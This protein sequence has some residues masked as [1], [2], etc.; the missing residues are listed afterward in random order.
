MTPKDQAEVGRKSESY[1]TKW[2]QEDGFQV[3]K[4]PLQ[5]NDTYRL[6]ISAPSIQGF[7]FEA[8]RPRGKSGI[9][10]GVNVNLPPDMMGGQAAL[11]GA[12]R[13][14]LIHKFRKTAFSGG[15]I[16]VG[17][18]AQNDTLHG[19]TLD[20]TLYDDGLTHDNVFRIARALISKHLE[21]VEELMLALGTTNTSVATT[22]GYG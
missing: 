14:Q 10:F 11:S 1:V 8:I 6:L 13:R 17:I 12:S 22:P 20:V 9:Q 18:Q 5:P 2:L 21:L 19:W 7:R 15:Y 4:A 16:G 3:E